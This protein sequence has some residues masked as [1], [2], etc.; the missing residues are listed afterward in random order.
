LLTSYVNS[1]GPVDDSSHPWRTCPEIASADEIMSL[2][3]HD[4]NRGGNNNDDQ[5]LEPDLYNRPLGPW[6][7]KE[8]YLETLF[9]FLRREAVLPLQN[10]VLFMSRA[11]IGATEADC[12]DGRTVG[13]YENVHIKGFT[14]SGQGL[15]V[16][17]SFSL[18]RLS[19]KVK[20]DQ[21]ARLM[22][23]SI[24][25][26]SPSNAPFSPSSKVIVAIVA[27]RDLLN[28]EKNPPE[29]DLFFGDVD[30]L[31]VD[32]EM[33]F[34]MI[35]ERTG[36][37]E[38]NR[39]A[40]VS[41]NHMMNEPFPLREHLL[42]VE[43]AVEAPDYVKAD[44][45]FNLEEV[46]GKDF[47]RVNV[48]EDWPTVQSAALDDSQLSALR[49]IL[50][51]R[52]AIIQG[53]PG[54]GKTF[55]SILAL[56]ILLTRMDSSDPPIIVACQTN[57]ALDQLL[58][59]VAKYEE[60]FARLGGRSKDTGVV[61][62]R[63]LRNLRQAKSSNARRGAGF[64]AKKGL[65]AATAKMISLLQPLHPDG[66]GFV[67]HEVLL[68]C[69]V[70]NEEQAESLR[71]G[72][73]SGWVSHSA[74]TTTPSREHDDSVLLS[75]LG[76]DFIENNYYAGDQSNF[77]VDLEAEE[78]NFELLQE[79]EAEITG[80]NRDDEDRDRLF[81]TFRGISQKYSGSKSRSSGF[82][83][84]DARKALQKASKDM[85]RVPKGDRG[86]VFNYMMKAAKARILSEFKRSA[87]EYDRYVKQL[88]TGRWEKDLRILRDQ[89]IIGM[90]TTGLSKYRA[91]VQ[92]LKPKIVMI[93]EA[94][95]SLEAPV[96]TA[97]VPTLEHLI[98]VGDHQQLRPSCAIMDHIGEPRSFD[99]SLFERMVNNE[100][101]FSPLRRQRRMI[102]E[103]REL[104]WPIYGDLIKDHPSVKDPAKRPPVPGMGN[105]S[106]F[107]F[108]HNWP[109]FKDENLSTANDKEADLINC[110]FQY[111][112][113]NGVDHESITV[114][115]FY[116]GQRKTIQ[117][118]LRENAD[119]PVKRF[120]VVTVDSYQGEEN[121]IVL[122]SL[123]RSNDNGI[124]G[125]AS[126]VNRICVALSRARRGF[127]VFGNMDTMVFSD[128]W[129]QVARVA[130]GRH[131]AL[132]HRRDS[133]YYDV[134]AGFPVT[135]QKHQRTSYVRSSEDLSQGNGGCDEFCRGQ[136]ACGHPCKLRCHP[137]GHEMVHCD[138]PCPVTMP[139]GHKCQNKCSQRCACSICMFHPSQWIE[140]DQQG[141]EQPFEKL[142]LHDS[143][144]PSSNWKQYAGR[145]VIEHDKS[146]Q[147]GR[148]A[149]SHGEAEAV[150]I[151]HVYR[152]TRAAHN[153]RSHPL[154]S[155]GVQIGLRNP[156]YPNRGA[157]TARSL[158]HPAPVLDEAPSSAPPASRQS[159]S[160]PSNHSKA[161]TPEVQQHIH[162][163]A[164]SIP[165]N[166][167]PASLGA[168]TPSTEF[169]SAG[170]VLID[171]GEGPVASTANSKKGKTARPNATNVSLL[172]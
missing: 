82:T 73:K 11:R 126:V 15:G 44:P 68:H 151:N 54:T 34:V 58:R 123:V 129:F 40:M 111:L 43:K 131:E 158:S 94:A 156:S 31:E 23:G 110:F 88:R 53:P 29:I 157:A 74:R 141:I 13:I 147:Q 119:L 27:A 166:H 57:H 143:S 100:V 115:T 56:R 136:L 162:S 105:I 45:F 109:E 65:E 24:V 69:D 85:W 139:C 138:A 76:K 145:G 81:G 101:E 37:Y 114:V 75:W 32:P 79:R 146:L 104:L 42:N 7:S 87:A 30:N 160:G 142:K 154:D 1:L 95:E 134:S 116:N 120:N 89:R 149:R 93:E 9:R 161:L 64:A 128:T 96:T 19:K 144:Q 72:A 38:A 163:W 132:Q 10:A 172:D 41:L 39:H 78:S 17:I 117:K 86:A 52:L 8:V 25:A 153:G 135:C 168:T 2:V 122:L 49:R 62:S 107:M 80:G 18:N 133:R 92:A 22:T 28:L 46:F 55:V 4:A 106:S 165:P 66:T 61:L 12:H 155:R 3:R 14:F 140:K 164:S 91:L 118:K 102:P 169:D 47:G 35:E 90:T 152:S 48:L 33:E 51:K 50:T 112:V 170:E 150:I 71:R 127:Y 137:Y 103:I 84:A 26:L 98:L 124:T 83:D 70:L 99:M 60:N 167:A 148:A 63:T 16:R 113:D 121:E 125:F 171:Y 59:L 20:W 159:G 108:S 130:C 5:L 97:C 21:S 6:Q 36:F 67:D 77:L